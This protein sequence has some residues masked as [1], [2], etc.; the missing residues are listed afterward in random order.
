MARP[1]LH[2]AER[3]LQGT[4]GLINAHLRPQGQEALI[5]LL[6]FFSDHTPTQTIWRWC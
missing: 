2:P 1:N 5:R 4:Q 3:V 6:A